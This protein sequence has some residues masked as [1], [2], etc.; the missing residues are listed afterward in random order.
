LETAVKLQILKV[1]F[2]SPKFSGLENSGI[3]SETT[4]ENRPPSSLGPADSQ[5]FAILPVEV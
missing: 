4:H 2:S 3:I 1:V 5:K